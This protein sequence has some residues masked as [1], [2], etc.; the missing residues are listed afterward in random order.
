MA[1]KQEDGDVADSLPCVFDNGSDLSK[2]GFGGQDEPSSIFDTI[3]GRF[4]RMPIM[5]GPLAMN[6]PP[7]YVGT[8]AK[9][10]RGILVMKYP[11]ERGIITNWDDM[12]SLF[13]Y[14]YGIAYP[15]SIPQTLNRRIYGI[16]PF[17]KNSK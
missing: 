8:H 1:T 12:V 5:I 11:V 16:I 4:R 14:S 15:P 17:T 9:Q 2:I 13:Y 3:V 7:Y 10:K 6:L